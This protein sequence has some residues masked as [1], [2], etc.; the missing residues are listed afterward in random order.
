MVVE[1]RTPVQGAVPCAEGAAVAVAVALR[2]DPGV[3]AVAVAVVVCYWEP[4]LCFATENACAL[5]DL[6]NFGPEKCCTCV[7]WFSPLARGLKLF[8]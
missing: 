1:E 4:I 2:F 8:R 5:A 6:R 3:A 7:S